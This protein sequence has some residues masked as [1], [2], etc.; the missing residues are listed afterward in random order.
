MRLTFKI[1]ERKTGRTVKHSEGF[2]INSEGHIY[3]EDDFFGQQP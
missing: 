2:K 1:Y 3:D